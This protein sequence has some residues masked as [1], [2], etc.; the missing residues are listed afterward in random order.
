M[1]ENLKILVDQ[2]IEEEGLRRVKSFKGV[3]LEVVDEYNE[4]EIV[5]PL[6]RDLIENIEILFCPIPP[7]NFSDMKALRLIQ[8]DSAG[9]SQ[10][11]DLGLIEKG[12]RACNGSGIFDVS[13]AE[14]NVAMMINLTRDLR[15]MIRHQ[16]AG[17][18][19]RSARFQGEIRGAVVGI[20]GYGGIGRETA[21]LC[22]NIGTRIHVMSRKGIRH[23]EN[24]YHLPG[25][26]DLEGKLPD[27]IFLAGQE[28]EFLSALDF[29]VLSMPLTKTT[30]GIVG[31]EELRALPEGSYLL[32]PARGLL[33]REEALLSVLRE[34]RLGGA[35]F[36][37][38]YYYPMPADHPLWRFPN[39]IMT[40]HISGATQSPHFV[41][42]L[43][44]LF[45]Q[46]VRRYLTDEPLLNE[47]SKKQLQGR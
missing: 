39:V 21:R 32:N 17:I 22:K 29:L 45:T 34:G 30:E 15:G 43:W 12:I 38:H 19:D 35:A 20:W 14:W 40:P 1:V 4:E 5:R 31:E 36:D 47:L 9:Y 28:K 41:E 27:R 23:R 2:P 11:F 3:E 25:T 6:P 44:E 37:A 33:V 16:E 24:T 18:W 46:N 8:I 42:R 26:S 10:L 7:E 13:I